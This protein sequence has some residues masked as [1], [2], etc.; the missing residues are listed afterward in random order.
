MKYYGNLMLVLSCLMASVF[1]EGNNLFKDDS[2]TIAYAMMGITLFMGSKHRES[3]ETD[4]GLGI[5]L[6]TAVGFM[7]TRLIFDMLRGTLG[8]L[9]MF[10]LAIIA[11]LDYA[12][13]GFLRL[14]R[15]IRKMERTTGEG[16]YAIE[17]P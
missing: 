7:S 4:F 1:V 8:E 14:G 6:M 3:M 9:S 2:Y 5:L 13:I 10:K 17:Q 15:Q 16:R 12:A 11:S